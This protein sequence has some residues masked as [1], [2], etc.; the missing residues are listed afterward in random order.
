MIYPFVFDENSFAWFTGV[1]VSDMMVD[2][3]VVIVG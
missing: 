2:L 3:P 1:G